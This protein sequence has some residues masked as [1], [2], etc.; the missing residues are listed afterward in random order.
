MVG[1]DCRQGSEWSAIDWTGLGSIV[2]N[3][4]SPMRDF[5]LTGQS[6][7]RTGL[8]GDWSDQGDRVIKCA[9]PLRKTT[10]LML[11]DISAS[12]RLSQS[13]CLF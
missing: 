13:R 11:A 6:R 1:E 10:A 3:R 8:L 7:F 12:D 2:E 4:S 9:R 5:R